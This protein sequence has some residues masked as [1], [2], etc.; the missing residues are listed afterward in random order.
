MT[1]A[2]V[3]FLALALCGCEI[4][5]ASGPEK[6]ETR[7]VALNHTELARLNLKMGA[8]ELRIEGG[9]PEL[10]D[11]DFDYNVPSWKPMLIDDSTGVRREIRIEQPS[12]SIHASNTIY[13]WNLRLNNDAP[14]DITAHLGA[15]SA[16]MNL[17]TV[18]LGTLDVEMGVGELNLDL[19]GK[20]RRDCSVRL[21][22]GVGQATVILPSSVAIL[23]N[24]SGGI[25]GISVKGL[26]KRGDTWYNPLHEN[27]P[28]TIR[29]R[30]EGGVGQINIV[31][32]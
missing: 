19:N 28:V 14:M 8:G 2:V 11:A 1:R 4:N 24:A 23:S 16:R 22:G 31:A 17:G 6:H 29:L 21:E 18:N 3:P 27:G 32:E 26:E 12:S 9:S 30:V 5:T 15:G 20:L 10:V 25:G 13:N 7:T